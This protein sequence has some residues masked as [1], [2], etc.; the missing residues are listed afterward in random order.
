MSFY[1]TKNYNILCIIEYLYIYIYIV[2][3][4]LLLVYIVANV[5]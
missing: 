5:F 4:V 2:V 3:N 1:F